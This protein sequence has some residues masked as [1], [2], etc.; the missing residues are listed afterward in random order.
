M[1]I[2]YK[3][4]SFLI[5]IGLV[6]VNCDDVLDKSDLSAIDNANVWNDESLAEGFLNEIY[7]IGLTGWS[8]GASSNSDDAIGRTGLMYGEVIS[9]S[10]RGYSGLY[11]QIKNI[12]LL[13]ENIVAGSLSLDIQESL[14]A[15]ALFFRAKHYFSLVT[16]YGGVPL[17]LKLSTLEDDL[18][19][20]RNKT[21]EC[22]AQIII[23]LD[24]AI[25]KLPVEYADAG[26]DYGRIT[27][28]AAMAFKAKVLLF[29]ASEQ[30]DPNQTAGRWQV[31]YDAIKTA[32]NHLEA[33]GKGLYGNYEDLWFDESN[34]NSEAIIIRRHTTDKEHSRDAG[35]RPFVVGTNGESWDKPTIDIANAYPMKDGKGI[36]DLS[37]VYTYNT[38]VF[39][40]NRDPR[41]KANFAYNGVNWALN[42][43]APQTTSELIWTFLGSQIEAQADS[44]ITPSGLLCRKAVDGT[45]QGGSPTQNGTTDWIEMRFA[46]VLLFFAEAANETDKISEAY[47]VLTDI[48]NR[49][50]IDSG[51]GFYGLKEG[52]SKDEMRIAILL[53]RRLE[54]VFE[55]K[56]SSDLRRRRMYSTLNG[57]IRRGYIIQRTAAFDALDPS[58]EIL[59][60]RIAL[61]NSVLNGSID[62][63]DPA[64]YDTYFTTII[65]SL[66]RDGNSLD[67]GTPINYQDEYYFYDL[68]QSALNSNPNLEQTSGWGGTF[69]PLQ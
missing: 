1:K 5:L 55:G 2:N 14:A 28:G 43:P 40:E 48:R 41:F 69:D 24:N 34:A 47:D 58:N 30:F 59:D 19:I 68:P 66:E 21:S 16:T 10:Q 32:K 57:T 54:L 18:E 26:S 7:D 62:L 4:S 3:L 13:L 20:P 61:E 11:G 31:A 64:V 44:R 67:D 42:D 45:I 35:V 53:E 50:G 29:Y 56:R 6:L 17:V 46:E 52:M 65:T 51:T 23:D 15:Q 36:D 33:N 25:A 37:S 39:W 9:D 38:T 49:A 8:N 27:K 22:I 12:N 63:S 60:D